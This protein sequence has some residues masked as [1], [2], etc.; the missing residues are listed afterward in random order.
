[1]T[2][3][4]TTLSSR[5]EATLANSS[6]AADGN[7]TWAACMQMHRSVASG[8]A[9][10]SFVPDVQ[11]ACMFLPSRLQSFCEMK[12]IAA[13]Q[14]LKPM[15][16]ECAGWT[17]PT[18]INNGL[19]DLINNS[20]AYLGSVGYAG[21]RYPIWVGEF[22]SGLDLYSDV[23]AYYNDLDVQFISTH[24]SPWPCACPAS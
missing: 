1:M 10:V 23:P 6:R 20:F 4:F 22:G 2:N 3:S 12:L 13:I 16:W 18:G 8:A 24:G 15:P 17:T 14:T 21:Q 5:D 19:N 11:G 7:I 9:A